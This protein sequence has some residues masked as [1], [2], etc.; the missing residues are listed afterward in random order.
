[1]NPQGK[2]R[3]LIQQAMGLPSVNHLFKKSTRLIRSSNQE[4]RG[5]SDGQAT[6]SQFLGTTPLVRLKYMES[7]VSDMTMNPPMAW[8]NSQRL[9]RITLSS[10]LNFSISCTSTV[11][12]EGNKLFVVLNKSFRPSARSRFGG[13]YSEIC[14]AFSKT[15]SS[16]VRPP[17][18][19]PT[20]GW[21]LIT[22]LTIVSDSAL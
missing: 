22:L 1:M 12:S 13:I 16:G 15:I 6:F 10:L 17:P 7:N 11:V 3:P 8:T 5:F 19:P 14:L 4:V 21:M 20:R 2:K 18:P 9:A